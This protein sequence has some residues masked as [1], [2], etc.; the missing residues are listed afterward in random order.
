[1]LIMKLDDAKIG[2]HVVYRGPSMKL[3]YRT[4]VIVEMDDI[5]W[6][7]HPDIAFL[8]IKRDGCKEPRAYHYFAKE[9]EPDPRC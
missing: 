8:R 2:M 9:W 4:G 1:M 6:D 7:K 3:K 5:G